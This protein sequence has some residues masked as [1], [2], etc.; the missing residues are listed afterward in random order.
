MGESCSVAGASGIPQILQSV[1]LID[2]R[3]YA[4]FRLTAVFHRDVLIVTSDG[5]RLAMDAAT[6]TA[7]IVFTSSSLSDGEEER[8]RSLFSATWSCE[9]AIT[10]PDSA[11]SRSSLARVPRVQRSMQRPDARTVSRT[12]VDVAGQQVSLTYEPLS[13]EP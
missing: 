1:R 12:L 5:E 6:L 7:P 8:R 4:Q 2:A 11:L 10:C 13:P 9:L 3:D